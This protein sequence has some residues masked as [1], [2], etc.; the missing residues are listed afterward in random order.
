M[1]LGLDPETSGLCAPAFDQGGNSVR[2]DAIGGG[3]RDRP[4]AACP[5]DGRPPPAQP[6]ALTQYRNSS[7]IAI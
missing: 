1:A 6:A 7:P 3:A 5:R 4:E 2:W